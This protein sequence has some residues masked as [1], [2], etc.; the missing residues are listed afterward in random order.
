LERRAREAAQQGD[1]LRV[2]LVSIP[3][4]ANAGDDIVA[5]DTACTVG[6]LDA[7]R[8]W[9]MQTP[10]ELSVEEGVVAGYRPPQH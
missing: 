7:E 5:P 9:F 8:E 3:P 10:A 6:R 2:A 4:H 1:G